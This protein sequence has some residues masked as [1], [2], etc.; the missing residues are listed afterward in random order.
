MAAKPMTKKT[1]QEAVSKANTTDNQFDR[2]EAK[3][4]ALLEYVLSRK[5]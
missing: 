5:E 1:L 2:T 3:M 4:D